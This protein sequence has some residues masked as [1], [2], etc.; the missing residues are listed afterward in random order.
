MATRKTCVLLC[1][2]A[3]DLDLLVGA[4]Y[5]LSSGTLQTAVSDLSFNASHLYQRGSQQGQ[6]PLIICFSFILDSLNPC[7]NCSIL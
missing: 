4:L 1:T 5:S 7:T 6:L 2:L 3:S